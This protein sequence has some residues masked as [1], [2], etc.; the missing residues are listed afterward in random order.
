MNF[1]K[2]F[3][4]IGYPLINSKSTLNWLEKPPIIQL[5]TRLPYC[6]RPTRLPSII[7]DYYSS[8]YSTPAQIRPCVKKD[9]GQIRVFKRLNRPKKLGQSEIGKK[10]NKLNYLSGRTVKQKKGFFKPV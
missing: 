10:S 1:G 5:Q 3:F 6:F 2:Y 4:N 7:P 9:K 8:H